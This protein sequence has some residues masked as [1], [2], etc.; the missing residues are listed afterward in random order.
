MGYDAP[1]VRLGSLGSIVTIV[2]WA[3]CG[4][5]HLRHERAH[6]VGRLPPISIFRGGPRHPFSRVQNAVFQPQ[7]FGAP[8][9]FLASDTTTARNFEFRDVVVSDS[10]KPDENRARFA[11]LLVSTKRVQGAVYRHLS[12]LGGEGE[13]K[14]VPPPRRRTHTCS[15]SMSMSGGRWAH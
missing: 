7:L 12:P 5:G 4:M 1:V 8:V 15:R 6:P 2:T 13:L 10:T 9:E 14:P 11:V 3:L